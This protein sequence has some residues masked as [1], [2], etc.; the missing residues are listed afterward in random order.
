MQAILDT[1][2]EIKRRKKGIGSKHHS[3]I[4]EN[5]I[6]QIAFKYFG[7]Y[8]AIP[9]LSL[10]FN[11]KEKV[12]DLSIYKR[13]EISFGEDEIRMKNLPLGVVEI[14]SPKQALSDLV[15][16]SNIYF[17]AGIASYWLVVPPL[18]SIYVYSAK[19]TFKVYTKENSLIDKQLDIEID[20][21][22]IF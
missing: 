21:S 6:I 5:L 2:E 13:D 18:Q 1:D 17:D 4:Q 3:I 12:P 16:K 20:L 14:L 8:R 22:K 9:E 11:G 10:E 19:K 15:D 7:I